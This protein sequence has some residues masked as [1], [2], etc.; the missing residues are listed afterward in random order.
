MLGPFCLHEQVL[1]GIM[2]RTSFTCRLRI[3]VEKN[4]AQMKSAA[5]TNFKASDCDMICSFKMVDVQTDV[6]WCVLFTVSIPTVW[7]CI[8][9]VLM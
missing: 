4:L 2:C 7:G 9:Y 1:G 8:M 5:V 3:R 6:L